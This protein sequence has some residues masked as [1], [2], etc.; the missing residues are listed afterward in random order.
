MYNICICICIYIYIYEHSAIHN[1]RISC[2]NN[3]EVYN[4]LP[5]GTKRK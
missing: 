3:C 5:K 2:F 4:Y 1:S